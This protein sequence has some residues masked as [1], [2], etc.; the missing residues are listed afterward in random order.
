MI[1]LIPGDR[2]HVL[3]MRASGQVDADDLQRVIDALEA[4]KKTQPRIS[5]YAEL[6]EMRWM[7]FTAFLRD[8]G[9]GLTQL[10]DMDRYYRAAIVTDKPWMKHI[11]RLENRVFRDL[12]VRTFPLRD[13][14]AAWSWV[15]H[16]PDAASTDSTRG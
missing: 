1:E 10:G 3:A 11:A 16:Q 2:P 15:E 14:Q 5:L 12:E 7:T 4:L 6:D 9:Y 13:K 8:L